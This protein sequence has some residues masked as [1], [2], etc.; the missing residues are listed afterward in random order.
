MNRTPLYPH[1][2]AYALEHG[3]LEQ[4]CASLQANIAC[5][6]AIE[7]AIRQ[8]FDGMHLNEAAV[9]EVMS[10]YGKERICYV[11]ANTLQQKS[12]DGRFSPSNKAWA[13]QFEIAAA[14]RPDYDSRVAF[15]VDS[16]PA[17]LDGF[18]GL[19][20]R[21]CEK[22]SLYERMEKASVQRKAGSRSHDKPLNKEG[23]RAMSLAREIQ[24]KFRMT[25]QERELLEEKMAL[26]GTVNMGAYLRKMAI[27]GYV[28]RLDLPELREMI[29]LLRRCSG[30]LNQ[31]AKRANESGRIYETDLAEIQEQ[32]D[33]LWNTAREILLALSKKE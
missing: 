1:T 18:T 11:V 28:L 33:E 24:V 3:E 8:Y 21:E 2:A 23:T 25:R 10:A 32:L 20:R 7:A 29:F 26:A 17:V 6:N 15:V 13:A 27:D 31:I 9:T 22:P 16:H 30:N 5:K 14:V 19:L 12:W 4:Y